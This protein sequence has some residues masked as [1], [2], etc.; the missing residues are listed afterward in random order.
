MAVP[1]SS[2][3]SWFFF[4][5]LSLSQCIGAIPLVFG[6]LPEDIVLHVAVDSVSPLEEVSSGFS[7]VTI[8]NWNP[9]VNLTSLVGQECG[10]QDP[11]ARVTALPPYFLAG[12]LGPL[13][14]AGKGSTLFIRL[15]EDKHIHT[16]CLEKVGIRASE[17]NLSVS[18]LWS[19]MFVRA[20]FFSLYPQ[21]LEYE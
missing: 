17:H 5:S 20:R 15:L 13:P 14:N 18:S 6:F 1:A 11:T 4:F 12:E 19:V 9:F 10:V 16:Q 21:P 3:P 7:C 2:V 8:F